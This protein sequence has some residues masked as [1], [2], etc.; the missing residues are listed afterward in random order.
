MIQET[1]TKD[2]Q[3][4]DERQARKPTLFYIITPKFSIHSKHDRLLDQVNHFVLLSPSKASQKAKKPCDRSY[5]SM[6]S[7]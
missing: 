6:I 2:K 7:L 4:Y 5:F 3:D 1:M